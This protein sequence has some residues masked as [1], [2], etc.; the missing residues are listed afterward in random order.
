MRRLAG[1][2]ALLAASLAAAGQ[3]E[4]PGRSIAEEPSGEFGIA[5]YYGREFDSLHTASGERFDMHKMTAAHPS[6]PFGTRV[7]VTNLRNGRSAIVRI[8]DRGPFL[9]GRVVDLSYAAARELRL[10]GPGTSRVRLSVLSRVRPATSRVGRRKRVDPA[11]ASVDRRVHRS[12]GA[13]I[14]EAHAQQLNR[15]FLRLSPDL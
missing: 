5:S 6:L 13:A 8:N 11:V 10:V 1:R 7:R 3:I 2:A 15:H 12:P 9:K 14:R 4:R